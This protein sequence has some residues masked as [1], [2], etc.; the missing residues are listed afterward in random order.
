M[1]AALGL[2]A[3]LVHAGCRRGGRCRRGRRRFLPIRAAHSAS[4]AA[5]A[6]VRGT[7]I[8]EVDTLSVL[9]VE[10]DPDIGQELV[11]ALVGYGYAASLAP[12]AAAAL[13][14]VTERCPDLILLDLGLPDLDG[15]ALCRQVRAIAV[16]A[17]I[18]VL[19]ARSQLTPFT[20]LARKIR[21][22]FRGDII[23]TLTHRLS[24]GLI[25]STNT[26]IRL[27]TRIAYGFKS[28]DALIALTKLH[29][30]GY[31]IDLPGRS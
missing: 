21:T 1:V 16:S 15:V 17:V 12:T 27:L 26:K 30:G 7:T 13:D 6:A 24:N 23:N 4:W 8:S 25:E 10:D 19:T 3:V 9:V 29:L 11:R 2:I 20:E 18:V 5:R 14:I 28:V 22:Y 31:S